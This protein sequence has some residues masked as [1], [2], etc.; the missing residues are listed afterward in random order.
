MV[1]PY[2]KRAVTA[3]SIGVS[4]VFLV[5]C[6]NAMN[7]MLTRLSARHREFGV[8]SALGASRARLL[9]E[10]V[11]ETALVGAAAAACGL[12]L[13]VALVRLAT[14]YLPD[15]LLTRT[16]TP[17]ALSWRAIVA[18]T[19]LGRCRRRDRRAHAGVDVDARRR[20]ERPA[21]DGARRHRRAIAPAAGARPADR[22]SGA[23]G[24]APR[25]RRA[26][27]AHLRQPDAR[28]SRP[29][30]GRGDHRLGGAAGVR[31]RGSGQPLTFAAAL[32]DRLE[33]MPGVQQLTLSGGV[34]PSGGSLY[35]GAMTIGRS[36]RRP[37]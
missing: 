28:R 30:C 15:A 29:E 26:T 14:G 12:A 33:Q 35:F 21:R 22:G 16:L 10:A 19:I 13:A 7:L 27:R 23:R 3:L 32:E 36:R 20:R 17:V 4:L 8:C 18:T 9:R 34:P 2:S 31:V 11:A 5:L 25:G 37:P 24:R 1:D 6:A